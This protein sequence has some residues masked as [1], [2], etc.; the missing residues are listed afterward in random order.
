MGALGRQKIEKEFDEKYVIHQYL[1]AIN[2]VIRSDQ[3]HV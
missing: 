3:K 2:N 1:L